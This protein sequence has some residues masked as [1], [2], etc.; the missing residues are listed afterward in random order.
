[1]NSVIQQGQSILD[2]VIEHGG[3]LSDWFDVAIANGGSITDNLVVGSTLKVAGNK[4]SDGEFRDAFKR[5][6]TL[7]AEEMIRRGIGYDVISDTLGV[8]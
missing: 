3:S 7:H 1:M 5:P 2:K 8:Y 4:N 6:A